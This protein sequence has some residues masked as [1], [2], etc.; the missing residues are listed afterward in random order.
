MIKDADAF[1]R[2]MYYTIITLSAT[3]VFDV[4]IP[5]G[6]HLRPQNF[7]VTNLS[8]WILS[9]VWGAD[10]PTNVFPSM[11][12]LGC[13]GNVAALYD[14]RKTFSRQWRIIIVIL[15]ILCSASTVLV[16]QHAMIDTVGAVVFAIPI[17]ILVYRKQIAVDIKKAA[18]CLHL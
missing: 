11:H 12:V 18:S 15:C 17:L 9:I 7:E 16:K 1:K 5:N 8:T 10:T 3:L 2:W 14:S 6:Q 4:I 13:I